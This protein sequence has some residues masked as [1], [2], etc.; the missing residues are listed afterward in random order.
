MLAVDADFNARVQRGQLLAV[1]D[2]APFLSLVA[3]Q[4]AVVRSAQAQQA[5]ASRRSHA[6][7]ERDLQRALVLRRAFLNGVV[8]LVFARA[9]RE[10][11]RAELV[12]TAAQLAQAIASLEMAQANAANTRIY[13]PMNGVVI[14]RFIEPGQSIAA[15]MPAPVVFVIADDLVHMRVI[16]NVSEVQVG[17]VAANMPIDVHV[18][19]YP[20]DSFRGMVREVRFGATRTEGAV[21][22]PTVI[23]VENPELKLRP[24]MS[25]SIMVSAARTRRRAPRAER[26]F[27]I[28]PARWDHRSAGRWGGKALRSRP[29]RAAGGPGAAGNHRRHV[30]RN[31]RRETQRRH[32]GGA[33]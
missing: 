2:P 6:A 1:I 13:A 7:R 30:Y 5:H 16:A 12:V 11:A 18:D 3:Q 23:D 26:R 9:A 21:S 32:R 4:S 10:V 31:H 24:G 17:H 15:S 22:Y 14:H 25:A 29:W 8:D 19:A 27:A 28:W 20:G 33:G